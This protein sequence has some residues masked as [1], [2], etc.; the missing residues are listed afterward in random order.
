MQSGVLYGHASCIDGMV[1][2]IWE[3]L[4]Y[5]TPVVA[6]GGLAQKVISCCKKDIVVDDQLLLKGL[7]IIYK[8]NM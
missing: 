8:K 6:T 2:R 4:G 3:D 5:Q 1:E 7:M